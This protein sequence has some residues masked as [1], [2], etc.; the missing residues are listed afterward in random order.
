MQHL[1]KGDLVCIENSGYYYYFLILSGSAFFGC[2]WAYSFHS[3][4]KETTNSREILEGNG[5]LAL[6]DFIE[7]RR[8]NSVIKIERNIDSTPYFKETKLK[9]RIDTYNGGHQWYIYSTNFEIPKK[10][11]K[12][13]PGQKKY[14]IASGLKC[15]D[16]MKLMDKKWV[17]SQVVCEEGRGQFPL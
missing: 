3:V 7:E 9:A 16:A 8:S 1:K 12:L 11:N 15:K 6:V 4:T 13:L 10:Q 17:I 2:Q 5:F 14:P